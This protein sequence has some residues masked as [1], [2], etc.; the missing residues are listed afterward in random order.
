VVG[1]V[2][3]V[4]DRHVCDEAVDEIVREG[5]V[6]AL[7]GEPI[8]RTGLL[9]ASP[10]AWI[11]GA[12]APAGPAKALVIRPLFCGVL[13]R[14]MMVESIISH[15]GSASRAKAA[16]ISSRMPISIQR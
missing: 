1:I 5:D 3:L 8:R 9:S 7:P 14:R 12:Q 11:F 6:V 10:A 2:A 16:R 4:G 13:M 15:S